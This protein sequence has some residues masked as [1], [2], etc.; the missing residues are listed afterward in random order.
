MNVNVAKFINYEW[1]WFSSSEDCH[2]SAQFSSV[3]IQISS[4]TVTFAK[5]IKCYYSAQVSWF[6]SLTTYP[7]YTVDC[8]TICCKHSKYLKCS[9]VKMLSCDLQQE[10]HS[11]YLKYKFLLCLIQCVC[12]TPKL[13]L[14]QWYNEPRNRQYLIW[15]LTHC[16]VWY[17]VSST[18]IGTLGKYEQRRLWK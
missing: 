18:N 16:T 2:F 9:I 5:F 10:M 8:E 15:S 6:N 14:G 3:L 11:Y 13:L 4:I 17:T 1:I 7:V 12:K